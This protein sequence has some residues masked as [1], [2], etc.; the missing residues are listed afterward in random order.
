MKC[1]WWTIKLICQN[2]TGIFK[3]NGKSPESTLDPRAYAAN[4][5][6]TRDDLLSHR[7]HKLTIPHDHSLFPLAARLKL[8]NRFLTA[9]AWIF[10]LLQKKKIQLN[11]EKK[12]KKIIMRLMIWSLTYIPMWRIHIGLRRKQRPDCSRYRLCGP[13][14]QL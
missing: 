3:K 5:F 1:W 4:K 2:F 8:P 10:V 13:R 7:A 12:G 6:L 9:S 14:H 11:R